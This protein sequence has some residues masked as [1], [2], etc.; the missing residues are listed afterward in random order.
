MEAFVVNLIWNVTGRGGGSGDGP[1]DRADLLAVVIR[2]AA[3]DWRIGSISRRDCAHAVIDRRNRAE[4]STTV[5]FA[6]S[7]E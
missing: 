2:D 4:K 3:V 1:I 6:A 7:S 5:A